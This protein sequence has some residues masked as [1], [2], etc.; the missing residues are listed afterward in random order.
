[1]ILH[2][3][4]KDS[5][6]DGSTQGVE[7]RCS[8]RERRLVV[9][10]VDFFQKPIILLTSDRVFAIHLRRRFLKLVGACLSLSL[11]DRFSHVS[12]MTIIGSD[13]SCV[14][15]AIRRHHASPKLANSAPW[16]RWVTRVFCAGDSYS[17]FTD[18]SFV[19]LRSAA[20]YSG[21]HGLSTQFLGLGRVDCFREAGNL[22][23]P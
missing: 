2:R 7:I 6:Q 12:S 3:E 11:G 14:G 13:L 5:A 17:L 8:R 21:D 1:M 19:A 10:R 9:G 4:P 16:S 23:Y 20:C 18:W 15:S 22:A